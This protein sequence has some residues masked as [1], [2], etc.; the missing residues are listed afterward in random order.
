MNTSLQNDKKRIVM[1]IILI[2]MSF[3]PLVNDIIRSV[4]SYALYYSDVDLRNYFYSSLT[5]INV[6]PIVL[7]LLAILLDNKQ[8]FNSSFIAFNILSIYLS[9]VSGFREIGYFILAYNEGWLSS[10]LL[11]LVLP[12]VVIIAVIIAAIIILKKCKQKIKTGCYIAYFVAA[13]LYVIVYVFQIIYGAYDILALVL[14]TII[15]LIMYFIY[16]FFYPKEQRKTKRKKYAPEVLLA[17][18]NDSYIF[19]N[20]S[21][22]EYTTQRQ[23]IIDNL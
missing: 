18:L 6:I 21:W 13:L 9:E 20:I 16:F 5:P 2:I 14:T 3:T 8:L 17:S 22:Q 1:K 15:P 12:L 19:G 4:R 23:N 11:P 7:F 10:M